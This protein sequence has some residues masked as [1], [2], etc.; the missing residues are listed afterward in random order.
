MAGWIS[1]AHF[2][3]AIGITVSGGKAGNMILDTDQ[4]K[5]I[6]LHMVLYNGRT[7]TGV[8]TMVAVQTAVIFRRQVKYS[9]ILAPAARYL[10]VATV[11]IFYA[12][13][14]NQ[15]CCRMPALRLLGSDH[16]FYRFISRHRQADQCTYKQTEQPVR[17]PCRG[18]FVFLLFLFMCREG[19]IDI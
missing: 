19:F 18:R 12:R 8:N 1:V 11:D 16:Q 2:I 5:G 14:I 3:Q 10:L 17:Y 13:V 9:G 15:F 6:I 7:V 4:E